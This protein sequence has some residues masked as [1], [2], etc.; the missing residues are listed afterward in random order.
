VSALPSGSVPTPDF[1]SYT[2]T[3]LT[4][5]SLTEPFVDLRWGDG[6]ELRAFGWWLRESIVAD[7][8]TDP[9]TRECTL[10]PADVPEDLT[11]TRA[12]LTA[13]GALAVAFSDGFSGVL[14][15]GWLHHVARGAHL[16]Q[17]GIPA[18]RLWTAD[19]FSEP[20]TFDGAAVLSGDTGQLTAYLRAL[21]EYGLARLAN[22]P[23]LLGAE[24]HLVEGLAAVTDL[25]GER[26]RT[27]FGDIWNVKAEIT[28][29]FENTTANTG[30]RLGPHTDLPTRETPP[31]FQFL[32]CVANSVPGGWSTMT[33]GAS[34]V[35]HLETEEPEIH[36]ALATLN[37][38]FFNRS[39][40][41][42]HRWRGPM[43][44]R[45]K[46]G[47]PLTLRAFYPVRAFPDMD[48]DDVP[49]AYRAA[50]RFH[51]LAAEPR[52]QIRYPFAPG[53]LVGF[54]NRRVLHGRDA[55]D[56]GSGFRHLRGAY[57]DH[58]EIHSRLRVLVR[59]A[60]WTEHDRPDPTMQPTGEVE[61]SEESQEVVST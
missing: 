13:E 12:A 51:Q 26:R 39:A 59:Q 24:P 29:N 61:Y 41:H 54:D 33:D 31:G 28:G 2:W 23:A 37:W 44:D 10:D 14:N 45:G 42:D 16:V 46:P 11:V 7:G 35:A 48:P 34:L 36:D 43:I 17:A 18:P 52:F 30:F 25:I 5:V 15:P 6:S 27:N 50:R 58:D 3:P 19:T 4:S 60:D 53:D 1:Y 22:V 8:A 32:H 47:S 38:V 57:V 20:P 56:P 9:A 21:A 55:F 49:R 40:D